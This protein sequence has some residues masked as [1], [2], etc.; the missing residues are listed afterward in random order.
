M[1]IDE[2]DDHRD[3]NGGLTCGYFLRSLTTMAVSSN[4]EKIM[5]GTLSGVS[6][7]GGDGVLIVNCAALTS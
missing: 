1:V 2:H 3:V 5:S 6:E 7:T 4:T